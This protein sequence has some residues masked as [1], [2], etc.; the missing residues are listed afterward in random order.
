M[1][2]CHWKKRHLY[3]NQSRLREEGAPTLNTGEQS[4]QIEPTNYVKLEI[5]LEERNGKYEL[6]FEL[7]WTEGENEK[8]Q[9]TLTFD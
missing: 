7:E 4:T 5:E 2:K 6:E 3:L 9:G 1:K 8:E